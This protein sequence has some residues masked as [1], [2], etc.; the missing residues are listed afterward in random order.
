MIG[1]F[2]LKKNTDGDYKDLESGEVCALSYHSSGF[3][4]TSHQLRTPSTAIPEPHGESTR[5]ALIDIP[6][7]R[8]SLRRYR[9]H[10]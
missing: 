10:T 6:K 4:S 5:L 8:E 7:G 9:N 3:G 1:E 2:I